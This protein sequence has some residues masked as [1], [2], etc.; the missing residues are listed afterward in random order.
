[1]VCVSVKGNLLA[2]GSKDKTVQVWDMETKTRVAQFQH[3]NEVWCVQFHNNWLITCSLDKTVRIWDVEAQK[4]IH[5]LPH[6]TYCKNFDL[7][8]DKTLLAVAC[9]G[10]VVLWDFKNMARIKEFKFRKDIC[11]ARFNPAGNKLIVGA[12]IGDVYKIDL[13]FDSKN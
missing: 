11:D 7:S 4:E 3:E 9:D 5:K 1:M 2:S 10:S 8:P 6:S 13:A 12:L